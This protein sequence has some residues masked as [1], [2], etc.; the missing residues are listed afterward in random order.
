MELEK[1]EVFFLETKSFLIEVKDKLIISYKNIKYLDLLINKIAIDKRDTENHTITYE[2]IQKKKLSIKNF[3][4][5][6]SIINID[7]KILSL[8]RMSYSRFNT[9][10]ELDK[11]IRITFLKKAIEDTFSED[12]ITFVDVINKFERLIQQYEII[13]RAYIEE[14]NTEKIK[15]DYEKR[16]QEINE[17]LSSMI[18]DIHTKQIILPIAFVIGI[19]QIKPDTSFF[20]AIMIFFGL[21][22]FTS[23]LT[24]YRN[25][26]TKLIQTIEKNLEY[27]EDFYKTNLKSLYRNDI[28]SRINNIRDIIEKVKDN[29]YHTI[30][31]S[32]TLIILFLIYIIFQ[33]SK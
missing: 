21:S 10:S 5:F 20:I 19:A 8:M 18:G 4:D 3:L 17:K 13:V 15:Y 23:L 24:M 7:S 6:D 16:I 30:F 27:W 12:E 14:L 1:K 28:S 2:I 11:E 9:K 29:M 26:Q 22:L 25:T 32:W 31:F 33:Y